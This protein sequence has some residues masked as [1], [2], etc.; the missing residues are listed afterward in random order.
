MDGTPATRDGEASWDE[1]VTTALLGTA[2]RPPAA[3]A[4]IGRAHV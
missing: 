2:R 4:E 1:L 3:S